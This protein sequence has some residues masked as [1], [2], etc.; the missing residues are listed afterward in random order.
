MHNAHD[1]VAIVDSVVV[2]IRELLNDRIVLLVPPGSLRGEVVAKLVGLGFEVLVYEDL[3][4][5]ICRESCKSDRVKPISGD[6]RVEDVDLVDYIRGSGKLSEALRRGGRA[7]VV[8]S[9]AEALL[10][11]EQIRRE[12][13]E[14]LKR[15]GVKEKSAEK[16]VSEVIREHVEV[17]FPPKLYAEALKDLDE[18]VRRVAEVDY[19]GVLDKLVE[20]PRGVSPKLVEAT[21]RKGLSYVQSGVKAIR[22]L[23]PEKT[24]LRDFTAGVAE[25][26]AK[27]LTPALIQMVGGVAS[28]ALTLSMLNPPSLKSL[29]SARNVLKDF[30]HRFVPR[31][32]LG[33][34]GEKLLEELVGRIFESVVKKGERSRALDSIPRLIVAAVESKKYLEDEDFEAVIDEVACRWGLSVEAF[35]NFV[36]NLYKLTTG[37]IV[38]EEEIDKLRH[39]EEE[40]FRRRLEEAVYEWWKKY[41]EELEKRLERLEEEIRRIREELREKLRIVSVSPGSTFFDADDWRYVKERDGAIKLEISIVPGA[42]YIH[43]PVEDELLSKLLE[44]SR[45]G[46]GL[47][48]LRGE[49]GV[50]KSI[51]AAVALWRILKQGVLIVEDRQRMKTYRPVIVRLSVISKELL[52]DLRLFISNAKDNR[53]FF[54]VFYLDPSKAGAYTREIYNPEGFAQSLRSTV[55]ALREVSGDAVVLMVL[56]NDQYRYVKD[57]LKEVSTIEIDADRVVEERKVEFL[58][59]II[60]KYSGC[61]DEVPLALA[62]IIAREFRDN[63]V[64]V[65]VLTANILKVG[66]CK[67]ED[68]KKVIWDAKG[69]VHKFILDYIWKGLLEEDEDVARDHAPLIVA[70]GLL[71]LYPRKWGEVIVRA[72]GGKPKSNIVKWFTQPL[73][74]TILEAIKKIAKSAAK[75]AFNITRVKDICSKDSWTS[76]TLIEI[77]AEH[78]KEVLPEIRDTEKRYINIEVVANRYIEK[79]AEALLQQQVRGDRKVRVI[80][81]IISKFVDGLDGKKVKKADGKWKV[82]HRIKTRSGE[83]EV[84]SVYDEA[85]ILLVMYALALLEGAAWRFIK[86][87]KVKELFIPTSYSPEFLHPTEAIV[88]RSNIEKLLL[89]ILERI[90]IEPSRTKR[91]LEDIKEKGEIDELDLLRGFGILSFIG[92]KLITGEIERLNDDDVIAGLTLYGLLL[93]SHEHILIDIR[94]AGYYLRAWCRILREATSRTNKDMADALAL[95]IH[96]SI[97]EFM[98]VFEIFFLWTSCLAF[99]HWPFHEWEMEELGIKDI[100]EFI[101]KVMFR[102]YNRLYNVASNKGRLLLLDTLFYILHREPSVVVILLTKQKRKDGEICDAIRLKIDSFLEE[103]YDESERDLAKALL[104]SGLATCYSGFY[105]FDEARKYTREARKAAG[106]ITVDDLEKLKP[107]LETLFLRL[108]PAEGLDLLREVIYRRLSCSYLVMGRIKKAEKLARKA[109]GIAKKLG[110]VEDVLKSRMLAYSINTTRTGNCNTEEFRKLYSIAKKQKFVNAYLKYLMSR[111][112]LT[113]SACE[114]LRIDFSESL[115]LASPLL[116]LIDKQLFD[117]TKGSLYDW[118]SYMEY[119]Y[120]LRLPRDISKS[121]LLVTLDNMLE[122]NPE[123]V[124]NDLDTAFRVSIHAVEGLEEVRRKIGLLKEVY[125]DVDVSLVRLIFDL[126]S[127]NIYSLAMFGLALCRHRRSHWGC[128]F[129]EVLAEIGSQKF[130]GFEA[131]LFSELAKAIESGDWGRIIREACKLHYLFSAYSYGLEL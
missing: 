42:E 26:F 1:Y 50:G 126:P 95:V 90:K 53:G 15:G 6:L 81:D 24:G 12:L 105:I 17:V 131:Q 10:V 37:S 128:K 120:K 98:S 44:A 124:V 19:S 75:R 108:D 56:S 58:S 57:L 66:K 18:E 35:K 62:E 94:L 32:L 70:R 89:K 82:V 41:R 113:S 36:N 45:S 14:E 127:A 51:A 117:Y 20:K 73:H 83:K 107:Y 47:I 2:K 22:A 7:I 111:D 93:N 31:Q 119:P 130:K 8:K 116:L 63:Y 96:N 76:C 71:G 110:K 23:G 38:T 9:T 34:I 91:I 97:R 121:E 115:Q 52:D 27:A 55:E 13:V 123:K 102:R 30:V 101:E 48:I 99:Y 29:E 4:R 92:E 77:C 114:S 100:D 64:L 122:S 87:R 61:L 40:E 11:V 54:P 33:E 118:D 68:I 103:L 39:L 84:E 67:A 69:Q 112:L 16:K 5:R 106:R 79:V 80:D 21:K 125:P 72:F 49:K 25:V 74:G 43:T 88:S 78:L 104:Y 85:D 60:E 129:A 46:G 109:C 59:D 28:A 86:N 65:A 3:Y